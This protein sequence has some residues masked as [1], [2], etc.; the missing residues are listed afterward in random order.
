MITI[1]KLIAMRHGQPHKGSQ[2]AIIRAYHVP[3]KLSPTLP[4]K[5]HDNWL[6]SHVTFLGIFRR[7]WGV[8]DVLNLYICSGF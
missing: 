4:Y 8:G 1:P 7:G 5:R 2:A 3:R 6:I